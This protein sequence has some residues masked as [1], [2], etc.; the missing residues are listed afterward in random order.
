MPGLSRPASANWCHVPIRPARPDDLPTLLTINAACTPGVGELT[1]PE[2]VRLAEQA[3]HVLV[4]DDG[5]GPAGFLLCL[6]EGA[7][8]GSPNYAWLSR[9]FPQMAYVDRIAIAKEHRNLGLGAQL[10]AALAKAEAGSGRPITCEVNERPANPGSLRFHT[11]LGF[12][13]VGTMD[14]GDKAVV[15]LALAAKDDTA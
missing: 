10:Y 3:A 15:F 2:L 12:E 8:Y 1:L 4:A 13:P 7:D 5:T 11:R 6:H 9:R 14:H